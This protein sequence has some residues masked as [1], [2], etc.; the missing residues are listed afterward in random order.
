MPLTLVGRTITPALGT[1]G[2]NYDDDRDAEEVG[3]VAPSA[4]G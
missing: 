4:A 2:L 3:G 1:E